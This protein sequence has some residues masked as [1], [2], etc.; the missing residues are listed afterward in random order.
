MNYFKEK[1]FA[2]WAIV[3]L[4]VLNLSTLTTM[5][6]HK[7]PRPFHPPPS[8]KKLIPDFITAELNL[9]AKQALAFEASEQKQIRKIKP[10]LDNLQQCKQQLF[11]S[12]FDNPVDSA[13]M[14]EL[15]N[16]IGAI[17]KT[18]DVVTFFH[19]LDLKNI[20]NPHQQDILKGLFTDMV[21]RRRHLPDGT[22]PP[23]RR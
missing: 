6:M 22:P 3:I 13:K 19:I 23:K 8:S 14:N 10:L 7:P 4:I 5:W 9:D 20:C 15:T 2:F 11:Q 12:A 17:A 16:Q 18:I 1:K 21:K